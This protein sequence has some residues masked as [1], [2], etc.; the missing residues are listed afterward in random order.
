MRY[1]TVQDMLWI[2]LQV[3]GQ[4]QKFV[5]STL[6][7]A[8]FTQ[9][10]YGDT[11][12]AAEHAARFLT[13]WAKF[14]PFSDGNELTGVVAFLTFLKLNGLELTGVT[15]NPVAWAESVNHDRAAVLAAISEGEHHHGEPVPARAII[16]DVLALLPVPA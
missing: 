16:R 15:G 4:P 8:T 10:V 11:M 14:Q 7:E 12:P 13:G 9:Y 6:E 1:L 3:T 2:N 5:Y